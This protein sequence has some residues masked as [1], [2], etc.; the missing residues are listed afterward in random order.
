M[1]VSKFR[2]QLRGCIDIKPAVTRMFIRSYAD[3]ESALMR[4]MTASIPV[5]YGSCGSLNRY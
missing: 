5:K 2:S 1:K 4:I 3:T